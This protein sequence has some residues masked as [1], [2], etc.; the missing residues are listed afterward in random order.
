[1]QVMQEIYSQK[2]NKQTPLAT[3]LTE[4]IYKQLLLALLLCFCKRWDII[5]FRS[6]QHTGR[7]QN[8]KHIFY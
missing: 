2:A 1:M 6:S 3:K 8:T 4:C 7:G 5:V